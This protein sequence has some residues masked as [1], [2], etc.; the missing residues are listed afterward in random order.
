[1]AGEAVK[2]VHEEG[3]PQRPLLPLYGQVSPGL[4]EQ[5]CP[6]CQDGASQLMGQP[7]RVYIQSRPP[8]CA[9]SSLLARPREATMASAPP[10]PGQ[11]LRSTGFGALWTLEFTSWGD[12]CCEVSSLPPLQTP[13]RGRG[14]GGCEGERWGEG[15]PELR[16]DW[17]P[18][19]EERCFSPPRQQSMSQSHAS[20][21]SAPETSLIV[22]QLLVPS[23]RCWA[24]SP[25]ALPPP[26][27]PWPQPLNLLFHPLPS[28]R[29]GAVPKG[30]LLETGGQGGYWRASG[31]QGRRCFETSDVTVSD[32]IG[33]HP[34]E[35]H[36]ASCP[37]SPARPCE[38]C[39]P[40][41][42]PGTHGHTHSPCPGCGQSWPSW[43][44]TLL[45]KGGH[46]L[47]SACRAQRDPGHC[48]QRDRG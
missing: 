8:A 24:G 38:A 32:P 22:T 37:R 29:L 39:L 16:A 20:T 13:R 4:W 48:R 21:A 27:S 3:P 19:H 1:M 47:P 2:K 9:Q 23:A 17:A 15:G 46:T 11:A 40:K 18:G 36:R 44:W 41:S 5:R 42:Q 6:H 26:H 35:T 10:A 30:R 7:P 14:P 43:C 45:P 31:T 25:P 12:T 28:P 34:P 33:R